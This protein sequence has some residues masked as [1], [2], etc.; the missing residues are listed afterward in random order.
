[1]LN[2]SERYHSIFP[3]NKMHLWIEVVKNIRYITEIRIRAEKPIL[4]YL[5]Q[6]EISIDENGNFIYVPERGKIFSYLEIQQMIDFWCQD[7]R[8]AFQNGIKRGFLTIEGGHRIGI[9]GE[10]ICDDK[11]NVRT[12]KYISSINIR[13]AHEIKG[14]ADR[15]MKY[16]CTKNTVHNSLIVSPPGAGKTTLLRDIVRQLSCGNEYHSGKN[17]GLVDERGE[18]AACF[19]GIPQLDVGVRT[20]VLDNCEK[21]AG[22]R[23]LLRC[24]APVVI[25]VDELG[26][27]EEIA[28]IQQMS[29]N[30]CA[31]IATIH[32]NSIEELKQKK[33]LK[34]IWDE[35]I[36]R[37]VIFLFR[38]EN[39]Y[40]MEVYDKG[41]KKI[42][43][44]Y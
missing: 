1:M 27:P 26:S 19:Q 12:V 25:A 4:I 23:M 15:L 24:M 6:K 28:L 22:M 37:N 29:G 7:S 18:I 31:V 42:C 17:V 11:G 39:E 3:T 30:G 9:C 41:E 35:Q 20:D 43:L 8:Y 14:V 13:I 2:V 33:N 40:C 34:E 36:F 10:V 38:E 16:I 32:G 21:A 5:N 44:G